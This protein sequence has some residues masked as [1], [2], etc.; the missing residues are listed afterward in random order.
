MN[1]QES[2]DNARST[3]SVFGNGN[4][5]TINTWARHRECV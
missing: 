3:G 5:E 2:G 1:N 4:Q